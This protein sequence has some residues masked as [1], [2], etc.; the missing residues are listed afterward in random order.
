VSYASEVLADAPKA[1]FRMQEASGLIQDSSGFGNHATSSVG[2]AE[3]QQPTPLETDPSDFSIKMVA[4]SFSIPN[5]ADL[6][7]GDTL[8]VEA[9]INMDDMSTRAIC[10]RGDQALTL[11]INGATLRLGAAKA[12]IIVIV[13]SSITLEIDNWYHVVYTKSG[14]TSRMYI[15]SVDRTGVVTDGTLTSPAVP[16]IVG[17]DY[18]GTLQWNGYLDEVAFYSTVLSLDRVQAHYSAAQEDSGLAWIGA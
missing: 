17:A 1:Y 10:G 18:N 5:D 13:E 9:W 4:D 7:F 6:T 15:D 3:Y 14:A 16:L 12:G 8:S 11:F 2:T